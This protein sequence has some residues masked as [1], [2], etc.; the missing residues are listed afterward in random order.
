MQELAYLCATE[1]EKPSNFDRRQAR[2]LPCSV[3][4]NPCRGDAEPWR[5]FFGAQQLFFLRID[6][7][8]RCF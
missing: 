2:G 3:V 1:A 4:S 6:W 5:H 8:Q 7:H